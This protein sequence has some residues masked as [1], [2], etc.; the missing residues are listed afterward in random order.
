MK[1]KLKN[2]LV[3]SLTAPTISAIASRMFGNGVPIFMLHRFESDSHSCPGT[4]P[5][6]LRHCLQYLSENGY[7]F[8]SLAEL[9]AALNN[10]KPL[11][12]KSVVFTI[13]DGFADQ[14]EVAAPIFLEFNCPVTIFLITGMLDGN[15]WPW[16]DKV[17]YLINNSEKELIDFAL[18]GERFKLPLNNIKNKRD[19]VKTIQNTIN[20]QSSERT[21]EI[22]EQLVQITGTTL[23]ISP[24]DDFRPMTWDMAREYE[25]KG[26]HFAPHTVSHRILSKLNGDSAENEIISSWHRIK[27]EL[28]SPSPIICYPT[29]RYCDYGPREIDVLKKAGLIGAVSTYPAQVERAKKSDKYLYQLPRFGFPSTLEE[30]I[31]DSSWLGYIRNQPD[32]MI[33]S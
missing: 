28:A 31:H 27:A 24:P 9:I 18:A 22:L 15:L 13:D 17:S 4:S 11:P 16:D 8:I 14:V 25:S 30:L 23:S 2:I 19:A 29:G 5:S 6:H 32:P 33:Y 1:T 3:N 12:P 21:D 7:A 10:T 20:A 26:I